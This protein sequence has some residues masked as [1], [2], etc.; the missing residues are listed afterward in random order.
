MDK[1]SGRPLS[2]IQKVACT[3]RDS[4]NAYRCSRWIAAALPILL[5]SAVYWPVR[6][7]GFVW[8]D[9]INFVEND[10]LLTGSQWQHYILR[11][12]NGWTN[13]FRPLGVGLFTIQVR[14]FDNQPGPMHLVSLGMHLCNTALVG[15]VTAQVLRLLQTI[16][17][18]LPMAW[19]VACMLFY[20]LHPALIEAV[21][22]IGVQFDQLATGF[23]L[24]GTWAALSLQ[25]KIIRALSVGMCFFLALCSK[26]SAVVFPL[27]VLMLDWIVYAR[28]SQGADMACLRRSFLKRNV[29]ILIA[30]LITVAGYLLFRNFGLG[31]LLQH[32]PMH[33]G[34]LP[35]LGDIQKI[36]WT[37]VS[38]LRIL[39]YPWTGLNPIHSFDPAY[40]ETVRPALL[41]ALL[42]LMG[43]LC[44]ATLAAYKRASVAACLILIV[45]SSLL[46]VLNVLPTG[47]ALSLYHERYAIN[48]LAF[49]SVLLPL[50]PWPRWS[51]L[52]PSVKRLLLGTSAFVWVASSVLT[53]RSTLP[54]W[55]E[56]ERLWRWAVAENPTSEV[57]QYNTTAALL[58]N[59][60][61][62]EAN[63]YVDEFAT[64]GR[65]CARCDIEVA[66][67]EL[68]QGNIGRGEILARRIR[69]S[70]RTAKDLD[71]RGDYY[72]IAGRIALTE[73]RYVDAIELLSSGTALRPNQLAAQINLAT[74]LLKAGRTEDG[75][76]AV[77]DAIEIADDLN[78]PIIKEWRAKLQIER[79]AQ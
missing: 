37:Y 30:M 22:W 47:F 23:M 17:H 74:A 70:P 34:D 3:P 52:S 28:S 18:G 62:V 68:N 24:L 77:D 76:V 51:V 64:F 46:P 13:Y 6:H 57:A 8:D 5:I 54:L 27:L 12:F 4:S 15:V 7:G 69:S 78:R 56:D 10:W 25:N 75:M 29:A 61:V 20:G 31:H 73:G 11:D 49:G 71:V 65:A 45:T 41:L 39:L 40:F 16:K 26:E 33:G 66:N 14:L 9:I 50:L 1:H 44:W 53:I 32:M 21:A 43:L 58:R 2:I 42:A 55:L 72:L 38:Y 63:R 60:K 36:V 59:G 19:L 48:A 35:L 79:A 67:V